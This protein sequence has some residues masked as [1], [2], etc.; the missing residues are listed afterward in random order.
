[1]ST[2][3]LPARD[4][5]Y[6]VITPPLARLEHEGDALAAADASRAHGDLGLAARDGVGEAG[7]GKGW[8]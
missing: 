1:M 5:R 3:A 2:S 7:G 8:G 4:A 6:L